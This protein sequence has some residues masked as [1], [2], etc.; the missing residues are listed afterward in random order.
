M[1]IWQYAILAIC[2]YGNETK[3]SGA[4]QTLTF[5]TIQPRLLKTSVCR[6]TFP[7]PLAK[8]RGQSQSENSQP[9]GSTLEEEKPEYNPPC[10]HSCDN[11]NPGRDQRRLPGGGDASRTGMERADGQGGSRGECRL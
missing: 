6:S 1:A 2:Q 11:R 3:G 5:V 10:E 9:T 8:H 4:A 7:G